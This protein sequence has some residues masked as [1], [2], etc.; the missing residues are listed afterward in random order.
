MLLEWKYTESYTLRRPDPAK[1]LVRR[2]RY[3]TA[4]SASDCPVR[5]DVLSFELILDEPFY[6]LVRQQLLAHELEKAR[7]QGADRVRVLHVLPAAN[8]AYQASLVRPEHRS[9]GATVSQVWQRMLV[10]PDRFV[11][12]DSAVFLDEEVTSAEYLLRYGP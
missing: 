2:R 1:D 6:Q 7:A 5:T 4:W 9:V 8:D 10:R 12:V 3:G 11:P